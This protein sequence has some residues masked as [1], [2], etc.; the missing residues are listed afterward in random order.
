MCV[1]VCVCVARGGRGIVKMPYSVVFVKYRH[2][3][4]YNGFKF[5]V[6]N[7]LSVSVKKTQNKKFW[8][9]PTPP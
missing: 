2:N 4:L 3:P 8:P 5:L 7:F 9:L 6:A 1:R